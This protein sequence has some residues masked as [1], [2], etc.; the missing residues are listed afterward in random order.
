MSKIHDNIVNSYFVDFENRN[1]VFNTVYYGNDIQEMAII[2]FNNVT[3]YF[4]KNGLN[5]NIIFDIE[6]T[7]LDYFI[8]DNKHILEKEKNY[9]WPFLYENEEELIKILIKNNV[10]YYIIKSSYG[11]EGWILADEMKIDINIVS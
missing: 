7:D 2:T 1:I 8:K 11:L 10:K 9:G 6:E 5:A 4:L 3:S